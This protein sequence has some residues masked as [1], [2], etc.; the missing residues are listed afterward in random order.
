MAHPPKVALLKGGASALSGQ[1]EH[2]QVT[3][4]VTDIV[5]FTAFVERAGEEAAFALVS[6]V[7]GLTTAAVH[8]HRGSVTNFTGDGILALFGA[9][10][11]LEDGPLRACRAALEIQ[12]RIAEAGDRIEAELGFRP[13][14]RISLTTGP[15]VLGAVDSGASTGVTAYGDAVNLAARLQIEAP[16]GAVVMSETMLRQVEGMIE[17]TP[18]GVFRF[19]G[20]SDPQPVHRLVSVRDHATRFDAAVARGLTSYVGRDHELAFL[21]QQ[22]RHRDSVRVVDIVGDPGIGKSR[23]LHEFAL[24]HHADPVVVL[25]GNCSADGQENRSAFH[26][27]DAELVFREFRRA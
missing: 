12:E 26:R 2:R 11:A 18:A 14:L 15:V 3:V 10:T 25:R 23:L 24:R 17:S 9:P 8:H 4:L 5:G 19:K 6:H 27:G 16:P 22:L 21:E 13:A 7:S 20:K 1:S